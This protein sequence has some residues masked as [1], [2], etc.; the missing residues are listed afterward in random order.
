[1]AIAMTKAM[2]ELQD[3]WRQAGILYPLKCR[4]GIR[5][6]LRIARKMMPRRYAKNLSQLLPGEAIHEAES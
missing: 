4:M 3:D 5:W 1:M 2:V 6:R